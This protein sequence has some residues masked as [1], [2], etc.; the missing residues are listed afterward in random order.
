MWDHSLVP[1]VDRNNPKRAAS[2]DSQYSLMEFVREFPDDD[3]CLEWLWRTRCSEDG[4]HAYCPKC[5]AERSFKK[6]ETSQHRQ[7]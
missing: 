7:S 3:S 4:E 5:E 6:Y 1:P 2:S